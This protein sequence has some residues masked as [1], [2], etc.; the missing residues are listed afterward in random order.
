MPKLNFSI[1]PAG[2]IAGS[3]KVNSALGSIVSKAKS[4]SVSGLT[5]LQTA[6]GGL[7]TGA[8]IVGLAKIGDKFTVMGSQ[9]EY[10]TGSAED[11]VRVQDKLYQ[12][13]KKTGTQMEDNAGTFVKLQQASKMTGLSMEENLTVIGAINSL[14]IKTGTSG[15]QASAAMLQLSQAL[16][17]GKLAGDEFR[18]MAEN[19][20]GVLNAL[21]EA[22]GIPRNELK[23]LAS[24]GE[25]TSQRLGQALLSIAESS[26]ESFS[27]LPKTAAKG[28]NAVVLAFE[29]AW[30]RIGTESGVLGFM[31]DSL[32][33]LAEWIEE[34]SVVFGEWFMR[35]AN[36]VK[37]NWPEIKKSLIEFR[38]ETAK[39]TKK[40]IDS[41]PSMESMF[42]NIVPVVSG[43]IKVIVRLYNF[44]A[45]IVEKVQ[46]VAAAAGTLSGGG[47]VRD[48]YKDYRD[49]G[50]E[51]SRTPNNSN[52]RT[53]SPSN[54]ATGGAIINNY[55]N[56]KAS[57]SDIENIVI[58][59]ERRL[60]RI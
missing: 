53:P 20:P 21:S 27:D 55:F 4:V 42:K 18:S 36:N 28:W 47:S 56:Y 25:L 30:A 7:A 38:T 52:Q 5:P 14:M 11:A 22:M 37:A 29:S 58:Q 26:D 54:Q 40:V 48:A 17:S 33:N 43:T 3:K 24:Q 15:I 59:Q 35:M 23:D 2:A 44:L 51:N 57:R 60:S 12:V 45:L 31:H 46:A 8:S 10:A 13:S 32:I 6:L 49:F 1:D 39:L 50:N 19:A 34:N 16:T 41:F 9:L